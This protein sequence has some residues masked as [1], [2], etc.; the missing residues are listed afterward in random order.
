[1]SITTTREF[2]R[3]QGRSLLRDLNTQI[4]RAARSP[5]VDEIHDLR[6]FIRRSRRMFA[7]LKPYFPASESRAARRTLKEMMALAGAVRDCDVAMYLL[8]K[9][10]DPKS[11]PGGM[12][13]EF[14]KR[15]AEAA[16]ALTLSLSG[17]AGP[18]LPTLSPARENKGAPANVTARRVLPTLINEFFRR[19]RKAAH[20]TASSEAVHRCRIAAKNLRYTLDFFAP[21]YGTSLDGLTGELKDIQTLLGDIHDCAV[22]REMLDSRKPSHD[23]NQDEKEFRSALKKRQHKKMKEFIQQY[24]DDFSSTEKLRRWK[25]H[26]RAPRTA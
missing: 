14:R 9:T 21:L 16:K 20:R 25:S 23:E 22:V 11:G 6:V 10:A 17:R 4:R 19:G 5:G 7:A 26:L 3:R 1:M 18:G 8:E 24:A 15:R 2:A 12:A 13:E